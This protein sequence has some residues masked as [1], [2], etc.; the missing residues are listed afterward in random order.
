VTPEPFIPP[1]LRISSSQPNTPAEKSGPLESGS[2]A[3][4]NGAHASVKEIATKEITLASSKWAP[5]VIP[6]HLNF[7][8]HT[9]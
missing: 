2:H 8:V 5:Y 3:Q 4:F 1:H 9:N 6:L 7:C